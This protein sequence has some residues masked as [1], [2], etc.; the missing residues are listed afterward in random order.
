MEESIKRIKIKTRINELLAEKEHLQNQIKDIDDTVMALMETLSKFNGHTVW[1]ENYLVMLT[2][3]KL[4]I[5]TD[6]AWSYANILDYYCKSG[7]SK[8]SPRYQKAK[9]RYRT[10]MVNVESITDKIDWV[11]KV[12]ERRAKNGD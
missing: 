11:Q 1:F 10:A 8:S 12:I 6:M 2:D 3:Y 4:S 7:I 5:Y 9:C